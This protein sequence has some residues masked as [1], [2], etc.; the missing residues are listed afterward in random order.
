MSARLLAAYL[1][2]EYEADGA[3][4]SP[5]SVYSSARRASGDPLRSHWSASG[6][7]HGAAPPNPRRPTMAGCT[8]SGERGRS[9]RTS[10]AYS[11]QRTTCAGEAE[12]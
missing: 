10:T 8:S 6:H 9:A 5:A 12:A 11:H 3:V 2:T 7:D 1:G 4:A